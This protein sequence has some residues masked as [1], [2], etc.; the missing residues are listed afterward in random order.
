[1]AAIQEFGV[2]DA[3][4]YDRRSPVRWIIAHVFRYPWLPLLFLISVIGMA[5]AQSVS[6]IFI[7]QAFDAIASSGTAAALGAA[8]F[9]VLAAWVGYGLCDVVNSWSLRFLAQRVER[10]AREELY[11]NLLGK[12]QAFHSRRPV[13]ELMARAT[14][15]VQ[16]LNLMLAPNAGLII[17]SIV[18]LLVPLVTIALL[19]LE[20]LLIPML[21]LLGFAL[22]LRGYGARL[23]P[24]ANL[25]R[26]RF[27]K[28]NAGLAEMI[29]GIEVVHSFAQEQAA[30]RRFSGAA[31]EYRDAFVREGDTQARYL[32]LL[33][34]GICIGLA[35]G[36]ALLLYSN[37]T[38]S[39][40]DVITFMALFD[41]LRFPTLISITT[42]SQLQLGIAG[43]ERIL[44]LI[45]AESDLDQNAAGYKQVMRGEIEF[46]GVGFGY[47]QGELRTQNLE[48]RTQNRELRTQNREPG[49]GNAEPR[50]QN[51]EPGT[52]DPEP[53]TQNL[54]PGTGD[55]ELR[56]GNAE[57]GTGERGRESA[58]RGTVLDSRFS[59]LNG[60]SFHVPAGKTVAL[61]GQTGAGKS[62]LTRL[63]N[64]T[65]DVTAGSV[66]I[67]G[68]DVREWDLDALRSQIA[69]IEQDIFLFSR[70]I[71]ENIAFGARIAVDRA[72]IERAARM[73]EAHEFISA[74][75][76]GY[77]TVIG[78]RG[79][80]LSGGQ[81]QRLAIAR[82]FL[83][84]PR[85]LIIDDSTSALDSA[86]EDRIQR[87][88]AGVMQG[89]TTILI[90]HRLSQI[91]RA[92]YVIL[93]KNGSLNAAGSHAELL[94]SS[95]LYRQIFGV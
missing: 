45:N 29:S 92:D 41:F 74:L 95:P 47:A 82:A 35:L 19:R 55:R 59:V 93:L 10:D 86:T 20:L 34:Y 31:G 65:F 21:Y 87:A 39:I 11:L 50:T 25:M 75:P 12:S 56:T 72:Q 13:G 73:A 89:R 28:L 6:A 76:Q 57:P 30:A 7:G 2:A 38:I 16:Q 8:A 63:I 62:S 43:A 77:D 61:I 36:H 81:R 23:R 94:E 66:R 44:E 54:E 58:G 18:T 24:L 51:L 48:P 78:E 33:F 4:H 84:D 70:S 80:T 79:V 71:A 67:D 40:G 46:C 83:S 15:D 26:S 32:P 53:G 49:T 69:T 5:S 68:V 27:G 42:V 64:R 60:I 3:H 14:N 85:I 91:R 22:S 17:E 9:G 1:M 37:G 88:M 52:G 90:T